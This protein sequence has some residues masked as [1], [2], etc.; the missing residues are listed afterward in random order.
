MEVTGGEHTGGDP[1]TDVYDPALA[2]VSGKVIINVENANFGAGDSWGEKASAS[3]GSVEINAANL[4][5]STEL[6]LDEAVNII[7]GGGI[8]MN[9]GT[10]DVRTHP[11]GVFVWFKF[12]NSIHSH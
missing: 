6:D 12:G 5:L 2:D 7:M 4:V 10:S 8:A 9:R 3:I 11:Q 1:K